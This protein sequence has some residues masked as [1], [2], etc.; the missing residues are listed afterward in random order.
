[1]LLELGA[2]CN[3]LDNEGYSA[4]GLAIREAKED[5]GNLS[6]NSLIDQKNINIHVGAGHF[7]SILHL[8]VFSLDPWLVEKILIKGIKID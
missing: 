7:G 2:D 5:S 1:M 6:A 4:L 3:A 8:A